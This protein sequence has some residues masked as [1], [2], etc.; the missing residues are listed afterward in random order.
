MAMIELHQ[1]HFRKHTDQIEPSAQVHHDDEN[2]AN[3]LSGSSR[4]EPTSISESIW[5]EKANLCGD[6]RSI[7]T[8]SER[9]VDIAVLKDIGMLGKRRK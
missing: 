3:D 6:G 4:K 9:I 8:G 5:D 1:G 7:S 2:E